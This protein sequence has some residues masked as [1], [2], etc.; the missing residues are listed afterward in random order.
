M[1]V[2]FQFSCEKPFGSLIISGRSIRNALR[3]SRHFNRKANHVEGV[4][5]H[6][7]DIVGDACG[8]VLL[9]EGMF[10]GWGEEG[11]RKEG[12]IALLGTFSHCL[13]WVY[14]VMEAE[15]AARRSWH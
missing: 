12:F 5:E 4:T 8:R 2:T 15:V 13:D 9:F 10:A 14:E 11:K 7:G 3:C 6:T 1:S